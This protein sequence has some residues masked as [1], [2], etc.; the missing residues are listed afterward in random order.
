[1]KVE[2]TDVGSTRK[3]MKIMVPK[4]EVN[5]VTNDIYRDI[6][7][8]VTIRGFRKGKAPRHIIKMY[9]AEY[10]QNELSKKLVHDKFEQAAKEQELFVVSMP[11]ITNEIPKE[12]EDFTFTAK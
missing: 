9:Y 8:S 5:A 7:Q 10:I 2:I 12:D 11:E 4:Q 6:S 1:M 3:E